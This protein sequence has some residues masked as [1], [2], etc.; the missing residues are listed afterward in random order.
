M[1]SSPKNNLVED[2]T[3]KGV[4]LIVALFAGLFTLSCSQEPTKGNLEIRVKDHRV[5]ID[6]FSKLEVSIEAIRLKPSG[7]WIELKPAQEAFDLTAYTDGASVTLFKGELE[8]VPF[9]GIH[10]KLGRISG[11]LKKTTALIEVKNGVRP[12][13]LPF[14]LDPKAG[15]LLVMDL[16]VMDLSDHA[17]R[18]YELLLNGYALYRDGK[19]IDKIPPG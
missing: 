8:S 16:K 18:G 1:N 14:S 9:E 12:V 11:T 10:L 7:D 5:A 2:R 6:D 3:G 19:L 15:T 4:R 17:G 13:Q